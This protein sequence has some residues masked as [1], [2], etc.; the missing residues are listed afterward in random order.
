MSKHPH[1]P[2]PLPSRTV[3]ATSVPRRPSWISRKMSTRPPASLSVPPLPS[4]GVPSIAL[5]ELVEPL[6]HEAEAGAAPEVDLSASAAIAQLADENA[7]L[8]A[9]VA[10][11]GAAMARL[12]RQ[13]LEASE[14]ELVN[15]ALVIAERVVGRELSTDPNLI[16]A[17][18]R[19]AIESLAA[20]D[21]VVIAVAKDIAQRIPADA[22]EALG[23]EHRLQTDGQLAAGVVE[24]RTAEGIVATAT[25]ARLG[26]VAQAL[27]VVTP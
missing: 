11:M 16:V 9:Q 22:W 25:D 14:N 7:A 5:P 21:E 1:D 10:E 17:W 26:A 8:R 18:A 3:D 2:F 24:V 13:V 19:E 4:I 20:K 15:L 12:R 27:G 23:S 6:I